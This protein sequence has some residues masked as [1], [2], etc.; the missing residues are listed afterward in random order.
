MWN[1]FDVIKYDANSMWMECW[2]KKFDFI[3]EIELEFIY[4]K[5][6]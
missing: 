5:A 1:N 3:Y 6:N 2:G 4:I